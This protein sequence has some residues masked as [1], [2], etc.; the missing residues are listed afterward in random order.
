MKLLGGR[1]GVLLVALLGE[2][3]LRVDNLGQPCTTGGLV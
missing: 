1:V 3:V 2:G